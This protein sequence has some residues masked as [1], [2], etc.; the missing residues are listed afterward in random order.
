MI[1]HCSALAVASRILGDL[2]VLDAPLGALTT[3]KVGG[4]AALL[5]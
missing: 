3:Y 5:V 1:D 2:A 4:R